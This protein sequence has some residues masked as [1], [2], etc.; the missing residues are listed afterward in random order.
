MGVLYLGDDCLVEGLKNGDDSAFEA[1]IDSCGDRLVKMCF[2]ILKDRS[3]AEDAVQEVFVQIYRSVKKFKGNSSL[4]TWIYRI[5]VNKCRDIL[6]KKNEYSPIDEVDVL[7]DEDVEKQVVLSSER[8]R[9]RD[10]VF[11]MKPIYREVVTLFYFEELSIKEICEILG[12]GEG[13]VKS[14]LHRARKFLKEVLVKEGLG[15]GEG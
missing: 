6:K 15:C 11:S 10:V 9:V 8:Q 7:S 2:L 5:A 3:L 12:E 4:Y 13:T 1:L 14:K